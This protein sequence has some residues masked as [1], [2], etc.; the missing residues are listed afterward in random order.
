MFGKMLGS[1]DQLLLPIYTRE[2]VIGFVRPNKMERASDKVKPHWV[3]TSV[4]V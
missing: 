2:G 4:C 1:S 3:G